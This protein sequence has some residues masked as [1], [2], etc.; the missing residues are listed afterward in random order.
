M[1]FKYLQ[2]IFPICALKKKL[3]QFPKGTVFKWAPYNDGYSDE[4][5][6]RLFRELE[7]FLG[8]RG[9]RIVK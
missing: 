1:L 8:E 3:A 7:S 4:E 9:A 2:S 6:K 5:K